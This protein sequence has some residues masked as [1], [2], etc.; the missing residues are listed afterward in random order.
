MSHLT[1]QQIRST[2]IDFFKKYNHQHI[3]SSSLVPQND[4][5]LMFVNAGMVQFKNL[6]TGIEK[7]DYKR[8][9]T[10]QKCVRA[11]GKHNDLENVGY[12]ARHHTFFE[13]LGNFSFGDYFKEEA[14]YYSWEL[15]TKGFGIPADK[16]YITVYHE[17]DEAFS[18]WKKITGFK[19]ER[20]IKISTSDN[21][22]S[23]GNSGPCGPCSEIFYD[24][25][26]EIFGSLPGTKDEDGDRFIE[27]WNLVFMEYE[28][29]TDGS[30]ILLPQKSVDTGMGLER[31]SAIL[32][33]VHN[34]YEIDVF[35][36]IIAHAES[37][38]K[39][40][41]Q[42]EA[43][44]SYRVIADHLRSSAF[45]ISDGVMPSNEGRGYVLRR[46]MRRAMRHIHQLGAKEPL[47]HQLVPTLIELFSS[48]YPEL[49]RA[50][51]LIINI[52]N[53][54]E[55]RFCLTL[56]KGLKLL[57]D[58]VKIIQP[59]EKMPGEVAFKLYDTYGFP[60]D[61]T[62]DILKKQKIQVDLVGFDRQMKEQKE[63]ARKVQ[64]GNSDNK[65]KSVLFDLLNEFGATE[66]LGYTLT[67]G[68]G[69]V[70][71]LIQEE[72]LTTEISD[73]N[74]EFIL[75]S[76][77]TPF[78]G[79]S[80]GQV[81][82][83]G[84]ITN[85]NC[86]IE[87]INTLKLL[88]KITAHVCKLKQGAIKTKDHVTMSIDTHHRDNLRIH[89]TATHILHAALQSVLG[90]H[91][92]Q[93][94]S[95]VLPNKLRF[96]ISHPKPLTKEEL[97]RVEELV[98]KIITNNSKVTTNLMSSELA[99]KNGAMALF[100][101]KYED[102][103]RVVSL[104]DGSYEGF[105]MELC[106]GTHV[107]RTGDIGAFKIVS[108][109]GIAA[110]IR[111]IEALCGEFAFKEFTK[112]E[113]LISNITSK[114]KANKNDLMEKI[115]L[116]INNNKELNKKIEQLSLSQITPSAEFLKQNAA[117]IGDVQLLY[118]FIEGDFDVKAIRM[119]ADNFTKKHP[120]LILVYGFIN[121]DKLSLIV[122]LPKILTSRISAKEIAS[123]LIKMIGGQ[124]GGQ[125]ILSQIGNISRDQAPYI[126]Q[127]I[128]TIIK[129]KLIKS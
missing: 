51:D 24:H 93:K 18:I 119:S 113:E 86:D 109:S 16:L 2:F 14:I 65:N 36:D 33:N 95:L 83:I 25:G 74:K 4:P 97:T 107:S 61:L 99:I 128:S 6:F 29:N 114:F 53:Q 105:S 122:S 71:A 87:V 23:M 19:D 112:N 104:G 110:G 7:R 123:S 73:K 26:E 129:E 68:E 66:F 80:G 63:R 94:G 34:N 57:N 55:E 49:L 46:I 30:R 20:I 58:E 118:K 62:E 125:D 96:D 117:L 37:I 60:L 75:I 126:E 35:Q 115:D 3:K 81:G 79:E 5:S 69:E 1:A 98:N 45:L 102:E 27:I 11:G 43:L 84:S 108:E 116:L 72:K 13:M 77:Q 42:G 52:L 54:E 21:F 76:S 12:T 78:Y 92:V 64:S 85:D 90:S 39:V 22:W 82:D 44:F 111:R 88:G 59:G 10:S 50:R 56:S 106:G 9:V 47:M 124:G 32:Q 70:I 38:L 127:N 91:V 28:Q 17:D 120:N 41:A 89:H 40:K 8:A 100:G 121:R 103:V 31:I 67:Q 101:E 15:L 48:S